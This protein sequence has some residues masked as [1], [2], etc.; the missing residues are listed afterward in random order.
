MLRAEPLPSAPSVLHVIHGWPPEQAGGTGLY[1]AALLTAQRAA[2]QRAAAFAAQRD[3]APDWRLRHLARNRAVEEAFLAALARE[4]PEVVH[5]HHLTGLSLRLPELARASGARVVFSLH[6]AWLQCLQGQWIDHRDQRCAG[7]SAAGCARCLI[8]PGRLAP[9]IGALLGPALRRAVRGRAAEVDRLQRS[10]DAWISPS[11]H[12]PGRLGLAA[13]HLPLPL[14]RPVE[15]AA[16]VSGPA[17]EPAGEPAGPDQPLRLIFVGGLI[18]SKGPQIA[19][20]A[21]RRLPEAARARLPLR[22]VGPVLAWRGSTAW[23][24]RLRA[25]AGSVGIPVGPLPHQAVAG[26]LQASDVLIFPSIWEENS[27]SVL[28][29]AASLGLP[30]IASDLQA[31]AEIAPHAVRFPVGDAGALSGR[32]LAA[33]AEGRRRVA[34]LRFPTMADHAAALLEIYRGA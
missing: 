15:P 12:L 34:P 7:P 17:G 21:W 2:G 27:P 8:P 31:V 28:R 20:A 13:A 10:V 30:V 26:A 11:R 24:E 25:E 18:P 22:L 3:I 1:A 4:R 33:L 23:A 29:E 9:V 32:L 6:D 5:F 14:L 19:L 16:P